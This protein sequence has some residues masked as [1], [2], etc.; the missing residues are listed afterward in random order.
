MATG[1]PRCVAALA[2]CPVP[3]AGTMGLVERQV[4][5]DA[6]TVARCINGNVYSVTRCGAGATCVAAGSAASCTASTMPGGDDDPDVPMMD[7]GAP[8]VDAGRDAGGTMRVDAGTDAGAPRTDRGTVAVDVGVEDAAMV[9]TDA[10]TVETDAGAEV[11]ADLPS[12][13]VLDGGCG[14]RAAGGAPTQR[15]AGGALGALLAG[16]LRMRRRR[17]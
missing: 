13:V 7:A 11:D 12:P 3:P 4:C 10:G 5:L 2:Q 1:T 9:A 17:R 8:T 14:C 6:G 15:G 16:V